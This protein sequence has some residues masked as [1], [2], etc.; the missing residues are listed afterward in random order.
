MIEHSYNIFRWY[1]SGWGRYT[2][3]D[4]IGLG[5]SNLYSYANSNPTM[6]RDPLGLVTV[7]RSP[8]TEHGVDADSV[9]RACFGGNVK[10]CVLGITN[11]IECECSC[12]GD[13]YKARVTLR[14]QYIVYYGV[15]R[16][17]VAAETIRAAEF[18]HVA[19][20]QEIDRMAISDGI[21]VES[22]AYLTKT[23]CRAECFAL[24]LSDRLRRGA[25][26]AWDAFSGHGGH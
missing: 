7:I 26:F 9:V 15:G 14:S 12:S 5:G 17:D 1:R 21:N 3:A 18:A 2:Q 13:G 19:D 6:Y 23:G 24:K 11:P 8:T 22:R 16:K 10:G 25:Y 4:P 20:L